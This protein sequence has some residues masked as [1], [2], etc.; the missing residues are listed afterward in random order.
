MKRIFLIL[1]CFTFYLVRAQQDWYK[2]IE[3][4]YDDPFR[5]DLTFH[6]LYKK[7]L[8]LK[9]SPASGKMYAKV[10]AQ[11]FNRIWALP[12]HE[13]LFETIVVTDAN[14]KTFADYF[15]RI[16]NSKIPFFVQ[17]V[18]ELSK[19]V[20]YAIKLLEVVEN[21]DENRKSSASDLAALIANT[22][23]FERRIVFSQKEAGKYYI[24]IINTYHIKV[25]SEDR[26]YVVSRNVF[27]VMID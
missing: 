18:G 5:F 24:T 11:D 6:G 16:G 26:K 22:G 10:K 4:V 25:G 14:K 7:G 19:Y 21:A 1:F 23:K 3:A 17:L 12:N 8:D 15:N 2:N 9:G 20:G 13:E 27:A